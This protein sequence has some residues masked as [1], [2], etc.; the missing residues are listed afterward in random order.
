[1]NENQL[2]FFFCVFG[3][4]GFIL[5]W[6]LERSLLDQQDLLEQDVF[7][8]E[9]SLLEQQ[10]LSELEKRTFLRYSEVVSTSQ[11]VSTVEENNITQGKELKESTKFVETSK[12]IKLT[13]KVKRNTSVEVKDQNRNAQKP[14]LVWNSRRLG[15]NRVE[16]CASLIVPC[17]Y[18]T[19]DLQKRNADAAVYL[20]T[21]PSDS[22]GKKKIFMQ[23]EGEHYYKIDLRGFDIENTYRWSSQIKKPYF[24]FTHYH[25]K[26]NIQNPRVHKDA[27]NGASFLARNCAS[28]NEREKL[29]KKLMAA[30]ITVH[31][32]SS[33]L[34]NRKK[35]AGA[36]DDKIE[37]MKDYKF[38]LAF[39]N[40]NV[41]DYVTEKVYLALAAGT[42]PVYFGAP[43]IEE[44][45][46]DG[47]IIRVDAFEST[48][49]VSHLLLSSAFML[50][51]LLAS[52]LNFIC[53]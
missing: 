50:N 48:A 36:K 9:R 12:P 51:T 34:N 26:M 43:N 10:D 20:Q 11:V 19:D 25:G 6:N 46:P 27:W 39:E 30:N 45:V 14:I 35:P 18:T 44:F 38:H 28:R 17:V 24:E 13:K 3:L 32:F 49:K 7:N 4:L 33:C 52:T 42:V 41:R 8:L 47:S 29:V 53:I 37:I 40:G 31:S 1:M 16:P 15:I 23:M 2:F 5:L 21:R 22:L